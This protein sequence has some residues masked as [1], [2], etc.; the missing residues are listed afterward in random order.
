MKA[1]DEN[2]LDSLEPMTDLE[3]GNIIA[4][5]ERRAINGGHP[6]PPRR[7]RREREKLYNDLCDMADGLDLPRPRTW[8]YAASAYEV[9]HSSRFAAYVKHRRRRQALGD[10]RGGFLLARSFLATMLELRVPSHS[11]PSQFDVTLGRAGAGTFS[12]RVN[13]A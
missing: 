8:C 3:L 1:P 4:V 10:D 7:S 9:S 12:R 2:Y 13:C 11:I 5:L 6:I